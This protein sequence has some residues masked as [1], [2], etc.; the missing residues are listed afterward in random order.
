MEDLR[1]P[2]GPDPTVHSVTLAERQGWVAEIAACP[3]N[4][5]A[6]VYGLDKHQLAT[7]Y[8]PD[9]WTVWQLVHHVADS[10]MNALV[11]FKLALTENHP[12][13]KPYDEV[14]W[15]KLPDTERTPIEVSLALTETLH[16]R[17]VNLMEAMSDADWQ[18]TYHHPEG[19]R[20]FRLEQVVSSYAWHCR[21]HTAHI[22]ALRQRKGW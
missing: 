9:G 18:R 13:I 15:A 22:T 7:P 19:R 16:A 17:W 11:R 5:R 10:H 12:T 14:A 8:R 1:Y 3:A 6:A 4:L 21:H 20:D 2:V